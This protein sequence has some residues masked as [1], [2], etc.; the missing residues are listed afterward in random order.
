MNENPN[1]NEAN[2]EMQNKINNQK[3][4]SQNLAR[5][6]AN[7][8]HGTGPS[9]EDSL[10]R[11]LNRNKANNNPKS[12]LNPFNKSSSPNDGDGLKD[13]EITDKKDK[14]SDKSS[15]SDDKTKD[16]NSKTSLKDKLKPDLGKTKIGK[17]VKK[18]KWLIKLAPIVGPILGMAGVALVIVCIIMI[19]KLFVGEIIDEIKDTVVIGIDR[20]GNFARGNGFY[21]SSDIVAQKLSTAEDNY[22]SGYEYDDPFDTGVL[23]STITYNNVIN[24]DSYDAS[25]EKTSSGN[26][27]RGKK[28]TSDVTV[29]T[30]SLDSYFKVQANFLGSADFTTAKVDDQ[31]LIYALVDYHYS[32]SCSADGSSVENVAAALTTSFLRYGKKFLSFAADF[33]TL[34]ILSIIKNMLNSSDF[35]EQGL[36]YEDYVKNKNLFDGDVNKQAVFV[37]F[38]NTYMQKPSS[39][40]NDEKPTLKYTR[41]M[42]YDNY[43]E[44][45]RE[46][47]IPT[48]YYDCTNCKTYSDKA[49]TALEKRV[50]SEIINQRNAYYEGRREN[51]YLTYYFDKDG[52]LTVTE[53]SNYTGTI[54]VGTSGTGW[55]QGS[56]EPW[57]N[58]TIGKG[59]GTSMKKIGCYVTSLAIVMSNSGTK[60][61]STTFDPGVLARTIKANG[62]FD[63]GGNLIAYAWKDLVPDFEFVKRIDCTGMKY[64]NIVNKIGGYLDEG[65]SVIVQVKNGGHFIAVVGA[66]NGRIIV[67]DPGKGGDTNDLENYVEGKI[68]SIRVFKG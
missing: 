18:I 32:W 25:Y 8:R 24:P 68:V 65:C 11:A 34:D 38:L 27:D 28:S 39:C 36:S 16:K 13:K 67:S 7:Q 48:I 51:N 54:P 66:E 29:D 12:G 37:D 42:N 1:Q 46:I 21:V 10:T 5:E 45:V 15:T 55:K 2:Q 44:Y 23:I 62:G 31:G 19:P 61:N 49:K 64:T 57:A 47:I 59:S 26:Y 41:Y 30:S 58:V 33:A 56:G 4:L 53:A 17:T 50:I 6:K 35:T 63:S 40:Q 60:I 14:T 9:N 3:I 20:I 52:N 22:T 43:F